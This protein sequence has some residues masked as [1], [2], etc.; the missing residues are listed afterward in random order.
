MGVLGALPE[1]LVCRP[2]EEAD[3][4]ASSIALAAVFPNVHGSIGRRR[5]PAWPGVPPSAIFRAMA[6]RL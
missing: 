3:W 6:M 5:L 2:I 4:P 1:S